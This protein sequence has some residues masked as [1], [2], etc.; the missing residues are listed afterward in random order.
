VALIEYKNTFTDFQFL[1]KASATLSYNYVGLYDFNAT[2]YGL[3][4]AGIESR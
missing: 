1:K 4:G 2:G 3:D